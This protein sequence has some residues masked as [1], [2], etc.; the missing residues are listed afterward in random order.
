MSAPE[1]LYTQRLRL[2]QVV[3]ED[4]PFILKLVNDRDWL[5]FIGDKGVRDLQ[6]ARGYIEKGP[7]Q[8]YQ[9]HG[10]GLM[11]VE[12]ADTGQA[13]GL[14]GILK[15]DHLPHPDLGFAFMPYGR[16][17]GYAL[18]SANAVLAQAHKQGKQEIL[19]IC[20]PHNQASIALLQRCGFVYQSP[21]QAGADDPVL[22]LYRWR[23]AR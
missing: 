20:L 1:T 19:A 22:S 5:T 23:A 4:A 15:R 12:R 21:Y 10:H 17:R 11:L 16:G 8:Q 18:E 14:C 2:R 3:L 6:G 9:Q 7:M 13:L